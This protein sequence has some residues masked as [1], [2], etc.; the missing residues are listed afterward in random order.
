[1]I[2]KKE[3]FFVPADDDSQ[4]LLS[5]LITKLEN[6]KKGDRIPILSSK[7]YPRFVIHRS[8]ID[9]FTSSAIKPAASPNT[10]S[11]TISALTLKQLIA[12]Q[13]DLPYWTAVAPEDY[14]LADIKAKMNA[15]G[16][17]C[18]DVFITAKGSRTE[19]VIGWV[20][21]VIIE[22]NSEVNSTS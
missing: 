5:D 18:Q 21:N 10:S 13:P 2:P 20:T 8:T 11:Q 16:K 6:S 12:D 17:Q 9:K 4:I 15:L 3:M 1:M 7:E 22:K 19:P 14:T